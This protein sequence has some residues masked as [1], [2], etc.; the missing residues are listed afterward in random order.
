MRTFDF[1]NYK[2]VGLADIYGCHAKI[3]V[4]GYSDF[5]LK[6]H[7][8]T[9]QEAIELFPSGG[10]VFAHD[11]ASRHSYL[12]RKMICLSVQPNKKVGDN[13]EMYVWDKN[14][15]VFE[16]GH[17]VNAIHGT[18]TDDGEHNNNVLV[19]NNAYDDEEDVYIYSMG[20][21]YLIKATSQERLLPYWN[22]GRLDIVEVQKKK[23]IIG[24]NLPSCN[25]FIDTTTDSQLV[26]WYVNKI[27]KKNWSEM[28][29]EQNFKFIEPHIKYLL[30]DIKGLDDN[31]MKS[32][33]ERLQRINNDVEL[34]F[35]ELK[36]LSKMPWL[37]NAIGKAMEKFK[38]EYMVSIVIQNEDE[39]NQLKTKHEDELR[40]EKSRYEENLTS[41]QL[42][43]EEKES[44]FKE[45]IAEIQK[46]IDDKQLDLDIK[47]ESIKE[48]EA[49]LHS[50]DE[51]LTKMEERKTSI[52][53]DFAI[54]KE[55]LGSSIVSP[56]TPQTVTIA[57]GKQ[58]RHFSLNELNMADS[59]G[60]VY[61]TYKKSLENNFKGN[62]IPIPG[63][64]TLGDQI[65]KYEILLVPDTAVA[66][67]IVM[68]TQRCAYMTEYVSA[69]WKSF[70][71]LWDNGLGFIFEQSN[72]APDLM[73]FLIL[74][75]INLTYLP[76]YMQPLIDLQSG[77]IE[78]L[79]VMEMSFPHNL[80]I[81][82]TIT[83]DEVIPLSKGCLK[84][85]GCIDPSPFKDRDDFPKV[86]PIVDNK[87]GYLSPKKLNDARLRSQEVPN[88]YKEYLD[89]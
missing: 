13:L 37:S 43:V 48:K 29:K 84:Y 75:N 23:F 7:R 32:R 60:F 87:V 53:E 78:K 74:Q 39:L 19:D 12:D 45:K 50:M 71:D 22:E 41:L 24:Y 21:I 40:K 57:Q 68:A 86:K 28:L 14:E 11:F 80:R 6:F 30:A 67:I 51:K 4:V 34:S 88:F 63:V 52:V 26:N 76:N 66:K 72:K 25:G 35:D 77:V 3:E 64:S 42:E 33:M 61:Q 20:R 89:E 17:R 46:A 62:N 79:P 81:L 85:M 58:E 9:K 54:V 18:F 1:D 44:K 55:V 5:S 36:H 83:G 70:D 8:L 69:N 31:I 56:Q 65:A 16:Y 59:E 15:E 38:D 73:H 10:Y 2:V 27:L 82:C 47:D 49:A